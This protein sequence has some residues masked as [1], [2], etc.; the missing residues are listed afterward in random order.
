MIKS[1]WMISVL[2]TII[3][4][5]ATVVMVGWVFNFDVL[6]R[7]HP[8]FPTMKFSTAFSFVLSA[9]ILGMGLVREKARADIVEVFLPGVTL[10]LLLLMGTSFISAVLD[11]RSGI[12]YFGVSQYRETLVQVEVGKPSY[13]TMVGFLIV[14]SLGV[15]S[16]GNWRHRKIVYMLFGSVVVA[17]GVMALVGYSLSLPYLYFS[18]PDLRYGMAIH[19]SVLFVLLGLGYVLLGRWK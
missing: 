7:V 4:I 8:S 3:A 15:V 6:T 18:L 5:T 11:F 19:T 12:E 17:L 2:I 9:I 14:G 16:V 10:L 13:G 1:N